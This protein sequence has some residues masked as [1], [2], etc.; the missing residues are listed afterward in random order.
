MVSNKWT[1]LW[2][3]ATLEVSDKNKWFWILS[4]FHRKLII[5]RCY[6]LFSYVHSLKAKLRKINVPNNLPLSPYEVIPQMAVLVSVVHNNRSLFK[7]VFHCTMKLLVPLWGVNLHRGLTEDDSSSAFLPPY[8]QWRS[9]KEKPRHKHDHFWLAQIC[10]WIIKKKKTDFPHKEMVL[11]TQKVWNEKLNVLLTVQFTITSIGHMLFFQTLRL[12]NK[13]K[14][15]WHLPI[16]WGFTM[17][18]HCLSTHLSI[19]EGTKQKRLRH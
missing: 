12:Q 7:V 4:D 3:P 16:V 17:H 6:W 15:K 2:L 8:P 9:L 14:W 18:P 5:G 13:T 10:T 1:L 19:V 11:K